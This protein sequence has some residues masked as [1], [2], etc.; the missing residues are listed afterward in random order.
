[1]EK[2][3]KE[4]ENLSYEDLKSLASSQQAQLSELFRERSKLY[5]ENQQ[6]MEVAMGKRLESMFMVLDHKDLFRK[7]FVDN[8]VTN[9]EGMLTPPEESDKAEE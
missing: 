5:A 6:L 8:I 3:V 7:E 1:M 2:K 9:I 4:A